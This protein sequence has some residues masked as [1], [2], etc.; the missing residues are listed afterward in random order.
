M[1]NLLDI[2]VVLF[3]LIN[4]IVTAVYGIT[5]GFRFEPCLAYTLGGIY[6]VF[7]LLAG[8]Y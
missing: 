3:S 1:A 6:L 7:L 4:L 2:L 8:G 5:K